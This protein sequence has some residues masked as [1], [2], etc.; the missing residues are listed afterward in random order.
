MNTAKT[1][2]NMLAVTP[3]NLI[4]GRLSKIPGVYELPPLLGTTTVGK[5]MDG[6]SLDDGETVPEIQIK[7][8]A[9]FT[10]V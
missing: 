8:L 4:Y 1:I 10:F 5:L 9:L 3:S 2:L 6:A 7:L